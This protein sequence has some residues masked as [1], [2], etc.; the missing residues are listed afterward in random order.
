MIVFPV[1][2]LLSFHVEKI[3]SY[4]HTVE[5]R[6]TTNVWFYSCLSVWVPWA[7]V[8]CSDLVKRLSSGHL[9]KWKEWKKR[10]EGKEVKKKR[11][12][13]K[14]SVKKRGSDI[15]RRKSERWGMR[16]GKM[17]WLNTRIQKKLRNFK[18]GVMIIQHTNTG[19]YT[20]IFTIYRLYYFTYSWLKWLFS[21]WGI[22]SRGILKL[23]TL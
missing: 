10:K 15:K 18:K 3:F 14:M 7:L 20:R 21:L 16:K 4:S 12:E 13:M 6:N 1:I 23:C 19:T 17:G 5:A 8:L 22:Y 9:K 2:F 11:R